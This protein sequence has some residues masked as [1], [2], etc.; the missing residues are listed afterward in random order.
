MTHLVTIEFVWLVSGWSLFIHVFLLC[1]PWTSGSSLVYIFFS[2]DKRLKCKEYS[3]YYH[4]YMRI[5]LSFFLYSVIP[6]DKEYPDSLI[7][8]ESISRVLI[9]Y[10]GGTIGMKWSHDSGYVPVQGYLY[11]K[12]RDTI[13]FSN[14]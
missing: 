5:Y 10:C 8:K 1:Y 4:S 11:N 9:I 14:C 7:I 3:A 13:S 12:L 6:M 2:S